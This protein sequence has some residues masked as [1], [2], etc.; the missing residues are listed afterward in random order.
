MS[1]E[2]KEQPNFEFNIVIAETDKITDAQKRVLQGIIE[3]KNNKEIAQSL[4][5]SIQTVKNQI[6]GIGRTPK[7]CPSSNGLFGIAEKLAGERPSN[8]TGLIF[9]FLEQGILELKKTR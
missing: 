1:K 4:S 6:G 5:L 7:K 8:R 2:K 9:I 3:G